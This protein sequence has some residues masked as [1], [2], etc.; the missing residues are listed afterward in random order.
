VYDISYFTS[1]DF[2]NHFPKK[3]ELCKKFLSCS[4]AYCILQKS[5]RGRIKIVICHTFSFMVNARSV[6]DDGSKVYIAKTNPI[7]QKMLFDRSHTN[8]LQ[9][10][11]YVVSTS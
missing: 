5:I 7:S 2:S 3:I 4:S 11:V 8:Q 1:L 9:L 10:K 6:S